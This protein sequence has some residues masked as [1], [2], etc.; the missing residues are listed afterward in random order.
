MAGTSPAMTKTE[1]VREQ[2]M[3]L[4]GALLFAAVAILLAVASRRGAP[5]VQLFILAMTAL[6]FIPV[7]LFGVIIMGF[8]DG[9]E[10]T[11]TGVMLLT[12]SA[13]AGGGIA[14]GCISRM[15]KPSVPRE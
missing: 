13:V 10:D 12:A 6:V 1:T 2:I 4:L 9:A 7:A 5:A 14:I 15:K 8:S 3:V 11:R